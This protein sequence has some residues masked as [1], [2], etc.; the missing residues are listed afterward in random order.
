MKRFMTLIAVMAM[1]SFFAATD[2]LAQHHG[3][4]KG[5]GGWGPGAPYAR[6]Y[7][8][9]TVETISGE[10]VSVDKITPMKGMGYGLHAVVKTDKETISVHLGPAWYLENQD[11]KI[12]PKDK[13]EVKGSRI[14]FEGKPA[15]IAAEVKKGD[16]VLTLRDAQ[17]IPVWS[18]WRRR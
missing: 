10:V 6:M 3:M 8:P 12:E 11:V 4:W 14:T 5:G 15:L 17:G 16:E 7:N 18:G 9:Q 13:I 2:T 1:F